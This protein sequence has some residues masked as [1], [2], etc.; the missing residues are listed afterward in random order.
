MYMLIYAIE[1]LN[2]IIISWTLAMEID[3]LISSHQ[4][5]LEN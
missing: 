1:V 3:K 2:I 4:N 5:D